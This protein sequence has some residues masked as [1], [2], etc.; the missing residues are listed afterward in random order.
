[1]SIGKRKRLLHGTISRL[2][3]TEALHTCPM[4]AQHHAASAAQEIQIIPDKVELQCI[5]WKIL[6]LQEW[7]TKEA[8]M[9]TVS[10]EDRF[11]VALNHL[12]A[13]LRAVQAR[14]GLT[15]V[16]KGSSTSKHTSLDYSSTVLTVSS[17]SAGSPSSNLESSTSGHSFCSSSASGF[18]WVSH[19]WETI[20][21]RSRY[22]QF[23]K[24]LECC[25]SIH[26]LLL[27]LYHP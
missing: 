6:F 25:T 12:T 11:L 3:G 14:H 19:P 18:S 22:M 17:S 4:Y 26:N 9:L 21:F 8:G 2:D 7:R 27:G 10:D 13:A 23:L 20:I 16:A 1:M 24:V 15:S 5:E